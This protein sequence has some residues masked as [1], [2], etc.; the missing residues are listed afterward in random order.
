MKKIFCLLTLLSILSSAFAA[1]MTVS[2]GAGEN[3][4][5]KHNPQFAVWLEDNDGNFLC[6]LLV[7]ERASR[8]NWIFGPKQGRPE[9]LPVWYHVS[10]N[11]TA[12]K[13]EQS[14]DMSKIDDV[15]SATPKGG[16]VFKAEIGS[17]PCKIKAEFNTSFD[18]NDSYTK[19]NSGVNGQPSVVY[20]AEIPAD[21]SSGEIVLEFL[22]TGSLDGSDGIIHEGTEGLTTSLKI[23]KAVAI[24][25]SSSR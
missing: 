12:D 20:G 25:P 8:K 23:V 1:E 3:W 14:S 2:I 24:V 9:S 5:S 7:T 15:T 10:K 13:T 16:T 19:K 11:Q 22:G 4:K 21:F 17:V 6:T 18:Y